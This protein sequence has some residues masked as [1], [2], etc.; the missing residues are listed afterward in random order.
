MRELLAKKEYTA[1]SLEN[2]EQYSKPYTRVI[3]IL[4]YMVAMEQRLRRQRQNQM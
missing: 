4:I 2:Q 1:D 3:D